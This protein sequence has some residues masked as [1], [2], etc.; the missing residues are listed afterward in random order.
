[1]AYAAKDGKFGFQVFRSGEQENVTITLDH[2]KGTEEVFE[3]DM[4]PPAPT[5]V[6]PDVTAEMR[7]END[8]R[9]AYED[10]RRIAY[11]ANC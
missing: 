5:S 3:F 4:V 7:A 8:R 2:E 9:L 1:M 10:S 11:I 6:L